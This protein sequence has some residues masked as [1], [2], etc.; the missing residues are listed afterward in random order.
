VLPIAL[1]QPI[2]EYNIGHSIISRAVISGLAAAVAEMKR[3]ISSA[4]NCTNPGG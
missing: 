1:I 4:E 2:K 3:L